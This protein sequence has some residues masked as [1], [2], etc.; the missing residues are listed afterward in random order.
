[1]TKIPF[2]H[3]KTQLITELQQTSDFD[4]LEE[5]L[6]DAQMELDHQAEV[7]TDEEL[8]VK[9]LQ[10]SHQNILAGRSYSQE[11]A[12]RYLDERLYELRNK[13]VGDCVAESF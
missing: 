8:L 7:E 11:E 3:Y 10:K 5:R 9:I 2:E 1:M 12:E 6:L 4:S 13:V